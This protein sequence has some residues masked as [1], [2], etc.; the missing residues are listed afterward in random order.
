MKPFDLEKAKTGEPVITRD[1]RDVRIVCFDR[2]GKCPLLGLVQ[3]SSDSEEVYAF[4]INGKA[5]IFSAC[6]LFMK[7]VKKTYHYCIYEYINNKD[8]GFVIS[9]PLND[10]EKLKAR[11]ESSNK[12]KV[13]EYRTISIEE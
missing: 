11:Y 5:V 12:I 2:K 1:G 8:K 9:Q 13:L 3:F 4:D 7:P 10:L 6:D